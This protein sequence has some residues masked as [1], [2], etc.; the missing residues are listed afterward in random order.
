MEQHFTIGMS[1]SKPEGG[2]WNF[3]LMY[4]PTRKVKGISAFDPGQSI[5]LKMSQVEFE[6]SYLW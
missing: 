2:T 3:S 6:V 1:K 5:E 4:A